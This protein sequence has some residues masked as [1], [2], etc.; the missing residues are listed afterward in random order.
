MEA[1]AGEFDPAGEGQQLGGV[2]EGDDVSGRAAVD[3]GGADVDGEQAVAG[4]DDLVGDGAARSEQGGERP[5]EAQVGDGAALGLG[6]QA[7]Q[8]PGLVVGEHQPAAAVED[9]HAL[10]D[11]VQDSVVVL[12][13]PG[14]L[15]G[16][17]SVRLAAQP[18]HDQGGAGGGEGE[19]TGAGEQQQRKLPVGGGADLG[20]AD[21]GGDEA[22][23]GAV[24][25][26]D[27]HGGLDE[28]A[29]GAV[30][31][32][33]HG[34]AGEGG[35]DVADELLADP[36]RLGMGVAD[37]VGVQDDDEVDAGGLA[38]GLGAWLQDGGGVRGAQRGDDA[39]RVGVGLGDGERAVAGLGGGVVPRLQHELRAGG[40]DQQEHD[41]HLEDEDLACD[42]AHADRRPRTSTGGVGDRQGPGSAPK[43]DHMP[44]CTPGGPGGP[45]V[46]ADHLVPEIRR[47]RRVSGRGRTAAAP[48]AGPGAGVGGDGQ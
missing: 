32:L 46:G 25:G 28:L 7:E 17:E 36:V 13:H 19:R 38:G 20:R 18:A 23:H 21:S 41:D 44:M 4:P 45:E 6:G 11:G 33:D 39:R 34:L 12:V 35:G 1:P 14:H 16:A 48:G 2:A 27:R 43:P 42:G 31:G 9:E 10:A 40:D 24:G 47:S 26:V 3:L 30:D 22:D 15:G 29:D 37:A 5:V 8:A